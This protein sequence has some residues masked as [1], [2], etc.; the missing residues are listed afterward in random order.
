MLDPVSAQPRPVDRSSEP[1]PYIPEYVYSLSARYNIDTTIGNLSLMLARNTRAGQFL[2][3]DA[4]AGLPMFRDRATTDSFSLYTARASWIPYED[5]SLQVSLF[6]NNLT[7]EEYVASGSATYSGFGS[8]SLTRGKSIHG[9]LELK[10][11][12]R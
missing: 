3:N 1:F 12:W 9:G 4:A 6:V 8:N 2:G 5:Y 7:D 11:E 10:Y